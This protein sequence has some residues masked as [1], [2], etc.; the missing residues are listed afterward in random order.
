LALSIRGQAVPRAV[1]GDANYERFA[2]HPEAFQPEEAVV[3][4]RFSEQRVL[5]RRT[6]AGAGPS[7]EVSP[8]A[9]I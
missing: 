6:H 3:S 1:D 9:R 7:G 4:T 2:Q 5:G 8:P